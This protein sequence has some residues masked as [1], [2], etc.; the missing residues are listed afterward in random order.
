MYTKDTGSLV[1]IGVPESNQPLSAPPGPL[2]KVFDFD[3]F[4]L[5]IYFAKITMRAFELHLRVPASRGFK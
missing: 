4:K 1:N 5:R 3:I 2:R